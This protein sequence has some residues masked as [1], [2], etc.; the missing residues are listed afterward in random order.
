MAFA[1]SMV[2]ILS[3][4]LL[5]GLLVVYLR[6]FGKWLITLKYAKVYQITMNKISITYTLVWEV[7]GAEMLQTCKIDKN[8]E[9][10]NTPLNYT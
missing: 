2:G 8:K 1:Y 9:G 6:R 5:S 4:F 7:K 3:E 10:L